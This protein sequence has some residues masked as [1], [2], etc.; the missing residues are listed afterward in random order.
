[1][2]ESQLE[3]FL[4]VSEYRSFSKAADALNVTQPTI[5]SRIKSLESILKYHLFTRDGHDISLTK[6]GTIFLEYARNI[7]VNIQHAKE[8]KNIVKS[9]EIKVGFSPGYS[10]SFII[11]T[12]K[13][14]KTIGNI[15]VKI[16]DGYDS[17]SLNEKAILGEFDLIFTRDD[18]ANN[19]NIISEY[20]FDNNLV[21]V[22]PMHHPLC[23]KHSIHIEDLSGETIFSYKRHSELWKAIDHKLVRAQNISRIDVEN[24]EML[25]N[26]VS[27][28]LGIGI[29]PEL[30]IDDNYKSTISIRKIDE[31][32]KIPNKVYVH[33]RKHSQIEKL[34]K[35]IIYAVINYKYSVR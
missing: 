3:T 27:N 9:P 7:L 19:T 4:A 1:M 16:V 34:A 17:V 15:N 10:Y 22:L 33:Y 5:T 14:L 8:V 28:E 11:E 26:S 24:N 29:I 2:N 20:L 12:L 31:L 23:N 21:V 13:A 35:K 18:Y 25:L 32:S 30:G 6:E